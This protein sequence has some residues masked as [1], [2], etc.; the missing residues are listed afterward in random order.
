MPEHEPAAVILARYAV[1]YGRSLPDAGLLD[2][3]SNRGVVTTKIATR[4]GVMSTS[5]LDGRLREL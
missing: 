4:E 5:A 2:C 1:R 3:R